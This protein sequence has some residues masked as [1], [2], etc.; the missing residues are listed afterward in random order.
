MAVE[1]LTSF[2]D[3]RALEALWTELWRRDPSATPFQSPQW[4]LPWYKHFGSGDILT[5]A[6]RTNG[7]LEAIAPFLILRDDDDPSESL[8]MLL[9]SGNSDYV[10][11]LSTDDR[12]ADALVAQ[13]ASEDC[14]MWDLQQLR[15]TSPLLRAAPP[16]GW[17][18]VVED[19]DVC[20]VLPIEGASENL[21]NIASTHFRKKLRYYRR[22]LEREGSVTIESP[23]PDTVDEL[24]TTLFDLHA[25]RW[26]TRGLPGMLAADVDQAFHRDVARGMLGTSSL[27]MYLMR[28]NGKPAA[29]FY[30]FAHG[31]TVY[32]YLSGYDPALER[33]SPGTVIVAHAIEQAV[34]DGAKTFDFL[35][36]AEDYKYA[37]G[38]QDRV[39]KRRR[40]IRSA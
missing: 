34:R 2:E 24:M 1:R 23:T 21:E 28:V 35:R 7:A 19:H 36:G 33:L 25:A 31:G 27:R 18:D 14:A 12:F 38:A 17:D 11:V 10:D 22:S 4:I 6:A 3:L 8:G 30:G 40:L 13:L 9:G 20:L 5:I 15:S 29:I 26:K 37:W 32:Y 16:E 39:N